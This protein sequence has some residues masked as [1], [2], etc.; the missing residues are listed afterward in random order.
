MALEILAANSI[1]QASQITDDSRN[2]RSV[3]E[4]EGIGDFLWDERTHF[5]NYETYYRFDPY[6]DTFLPPTLVKEIRQFADS[7]L[8]HL[9]SFD[10]SEENRIISKYS[11]SPSKIKK[12][13]AQLSSVCVEAEKNKCGLVGLGD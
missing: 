13:A 9:D 4:W 12:F 11:V 7:V 2:Y 5:L 10:L 8:R 3:A 6:R 1:Q